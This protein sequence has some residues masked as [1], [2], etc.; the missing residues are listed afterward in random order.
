MYGLRNNMTEQEKLYRL[1]EEIETW[2]SR[3][4][5]AEKA[6]TETDDILKEVKRVKDV[7]Y[8]FS[9]VLLA[10]WVAT[11]IFARFGFWK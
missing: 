10:L 2:K 1:F 4:I 11:I 9:W 6:K 8:V 7:Y 3:A 5:K